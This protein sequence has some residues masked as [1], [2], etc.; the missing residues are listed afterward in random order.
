MS[1]GDMCGVSVFDYQAR[2]WRSNAIDLSQ[3]VEVFV[4]VMV[5]QEAE[6]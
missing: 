5:G 4:G 3:P 1:D 2:F 6:S